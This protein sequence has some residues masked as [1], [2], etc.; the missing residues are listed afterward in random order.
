MCRWNLLW[1]FCDIM[2][3]A[4]FQRHESGGTKKKRSLMSLNLW[5]TRLGVADS[6]GRG[7]DCSCLDSIWCTPSM[8]ATILNL[9]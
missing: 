6:N 3:E 7:L 1:I 9:V 8:T 5:E 4:N 2:L